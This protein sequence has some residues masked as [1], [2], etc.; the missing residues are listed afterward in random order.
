MATNN[1]VNSSFPSGFS[2]SG[3]TVSAAG[4]A[5]NTKQSAFSY[6][7]TMAVTDVT[8]DNTTY[9]IIFD[10]KIFDN[11][12]DFNPSTGTFTAPVT[13]LYLFNFN[14]LL[15]SVDPTDSLIQTTITTT[16]FTYNGSYIS[17]SASLASGGF[18]SPGTTTAIAVMTAGD[19][20]NCQVSVF[21]GTKTVGIDNGSFTYIGGYLIC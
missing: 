11:N 18:Y 19:I 5:T 4:E 16:Q 14:C 21:G 17:D 6:N 12:N 8:G 20:M 13:G 2:S 1:S 10:N 7:L 9:T 3:L 15:T